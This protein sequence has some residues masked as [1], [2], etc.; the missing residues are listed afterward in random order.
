MLTGA[1][2]LPTSS[3][4]SL[5]AIVCAWML[6]AALTTLLLDVTPLPG[7]ASTLLVDAST[8]AS[9]IARP[10]L[11]IDMMCTFLD[12]IDWPRAKRNVS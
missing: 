2:S 3:S 5:F 11:F 8:Q 4:S 6:T 12:E 7:V 1:R 10:A 9:A